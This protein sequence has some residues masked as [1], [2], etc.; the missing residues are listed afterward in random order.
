M[1]NKEVATM[2]SEWFAN[3][4]SDTS[5]QWQR[6]NA[7][8]KA[9]NVNLKIR[10][11]ITAHARNRQILQRLA[12]SMLVETEKAAVIAWHV[13]LIR[14]RTTQRAHQIMKRVV[15][16]MQHRDISL[17]WAECKQSYTSAMCQVLRS[18]SV[19]LKRAELS[20]SG[21]VEELQRK[22]FNIRQ[23]FR[24]KTMIRVICRMKHRAIANTL[25]SW[26]Q[27]MKGT[28]LCTRGFKL[29][30]LQLHRHMS[31]TVLNALSNWERSMQAANTAL[32][33]D[34]IL[35]YAAGSHKTA[36]QV[37]ESQASRKWFMNVFKALLK[38]YSLALIIAQK[39]RVFLTWNF[40]WRRHHDVADLKRLMA[41]VDR[42]KV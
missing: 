2:F 41:Y 30:K 36:L 34:K 37:R 4:K 11:G 20:S 32:Q 14:F 13:N 10:L 15:G 23:A 16:V 19:Q 35:D 24:N 39:E 7:R 28:K 25:I 38:K 27:K 5:N 17:A 1:R 26:Q 42:K 12:E 3:W 29:I 31:K 9:E 33:K 6:E 8:L 21:E 22:M 40:Q 18:L